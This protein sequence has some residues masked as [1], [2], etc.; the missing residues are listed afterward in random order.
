MRSLR[1]VSIPH[2]IVKYTNAFI[3]PR[4]VAATG[5]NNWAPTSYARALTEKEDALG[6]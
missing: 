6:A 2:I 3:H 5:G 1:Y 4:R